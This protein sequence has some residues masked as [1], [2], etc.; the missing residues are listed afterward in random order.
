MLLFEFNNVREFKKSVGELKAEMEADIKAEVKNATLAMETRIKR[1]APVNEGDLRKSIDHEFTNGG[2][3]GTVYTTKEH[4]LYNEFG[5]G[6]YAVEGNG[7][8]TPWA[9]PKRAA[10]AKEYNFP[11]I[12]INGEEFY[13]THGQKPQPFFFKNFDYIRPRFERELEKIIRG[14]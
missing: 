13:L 10:G 11:I 2:L 8:K 7:R 14:R 5:T 1:D 6:I 12:M 3:V 4:A 9:F